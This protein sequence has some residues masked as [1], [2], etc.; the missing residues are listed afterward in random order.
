MS[1]LERT[2]EA[3]LKALYWSITATEIVLFVVVFPLIAWICGAGLMAAL[4]W[5]VYF[6]IGVVGSLGGC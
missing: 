3:C 4:L 1:V 5:G 2:L 6:L